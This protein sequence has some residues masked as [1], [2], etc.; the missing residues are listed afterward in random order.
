MY[1]T[2]KTQYKIFLVDGFCPSCQ[3][4]G[5]IMSGGFCPGGGDCVRRDFVLHSPRSAYPVSTAQRFAD[6]LGH[7]RLTTLGSRHPSSDGALTINL[8][9]R[10]RPNT[11]TKYVRARY[12]RS[13]F[14]G[15]DCWVAPSEYCSLSLLLTGKRCSLDNPPGNCISLCA[16]LPVTKFLVPVYYAET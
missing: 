9:W 2:I 15:P 4:G 5:G 3:L 11:N 8:S 13:C 12:K 10:L 16:S 1:N 14:R 7:L 6:H